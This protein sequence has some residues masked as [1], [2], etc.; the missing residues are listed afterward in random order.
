M[1]TYR[2]YGAT[3]GLTASGVTDRLGL[4]PSRSVEVGERPSPKAQIAQASYWALSSGEAPED[5]AELTETLT[6]VLDQLH[7]VRKQLWNL[8]DEGY[9]IDWFCYL[10]SHATEHAAELPRAFMQRLLDVPGA[11]LLDVYEDYDDEI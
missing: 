5:G 9:D 6:R 8:A 3:A 10:G 1:A 4:V 11:L 7:P 2:V